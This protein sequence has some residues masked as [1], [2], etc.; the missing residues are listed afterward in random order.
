MSSVFQIINFKHLADVI[1]VPA[2][3]ISAETY[4]EQT[5]VL[6]GTTCIR[7]KGYRYKNSGRSLYTEEK[8][9]REDT[10]LT[11]VPY[12]IWGNRGENQMRV[13]MLEE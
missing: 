7:V 2:I 1:V 9:T 6:K 8:P 4:T 13:W 11:A 10:Y 12:Y 3:N 5:G